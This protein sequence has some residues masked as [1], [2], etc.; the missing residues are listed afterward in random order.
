MRWVCAEIFSLEVWVQRNIT[1]GYT[2]W[3][4]KRCSR[5]LHAGVQ[6]LRGLFIY[7][8]FFHLWGVWQ[9]GLCP[10]GGITIR[11][12]TQNCYSSN[13]HTT[14]PLLFPLFRNRKGWG[15]AWALP[16]N[17]DDNSMCCV[18]CDHHPQP[19]SVNLNQNN[20][21]LNGK[22]PDSGDLVPLRQAESPVWAW[23]WVNYT[24]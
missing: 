17:T 2:G 6:F 24:W 8:K 22:T 10:Q 20:L 11:L 9:N 15:L 3:V 16:L 5:C 7:L 13:V 18:V 14:A 12:S 23:V 1:T 19:P 21:Q 4:L